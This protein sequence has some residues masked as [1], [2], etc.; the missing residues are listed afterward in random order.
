MSAVQRAARSSSTPS[1]TV[2]ETSSARAAVSVR[3]IASPSKYLLFVGSRLTEQ[4]TPSRSAKVASSALANATVSYDWPASFTPRRP[5]RNANLPESVPEPHSVPVTGYGASPTFASVA[6]APSV[7][8]SAR[9]TNGVT[10]I[11]K[12]SSSKATKL[13]PFTATATIA[14]LAMPDCPL[15]PKPPDVSPK[16]ISNACQPF[17]AYHQESLPYV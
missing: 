15:T 9:P 14:L 5:P 3:P 16:C 10:P 8:V 11:W 6:P 4:S 13:P 7:V 2:N 1:P 17:A 12:W